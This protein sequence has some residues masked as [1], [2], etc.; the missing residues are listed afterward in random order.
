MAFNL[1][2]PISIMQYGVHVGKVLWTIGPKYFSWVSNQE[3]TPATEKTL[4][5]AQQMYDNQGSF[6]VLKKRKDKLYIVELVVIMQSERMAQARIDDNDPEWIYFV[7]PIQERQPTKLPPGYF[8][9]KDDDIRPNK[10]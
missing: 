8:P 4:E 2:S 3:I 9:D 1:T 7:Y 6:A 10:N 5:A